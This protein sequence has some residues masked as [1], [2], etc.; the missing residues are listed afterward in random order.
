M[1]AG[2]WGGGVESVALFTGTPWK[3][4][5]HFS[6]DM[7]NK[8]ALGPNAPGTKSCSWASAW[9]I[10]STWGV[11]LLGITS[12]SFIAFWSTGGS[13]LFHRLFGMGTMPAFP[14]PFAAS[15]TGTSP[16]LSVPACSM[17]EGDSA[18]VKDDQ[19]ACCKAA[20]VVTNW[21]SKYLPT[22]CTLPTATSQYNASTPPTATHR[23]LLGM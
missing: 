11:G 7:T 4:R 20:T 6:W 17:G 10:A 8:S 14:T 9:T 2:A 23:S 1:L 16:A 15:S 21:V 3:M 5:E 19:S 12:T 13:C 22:A 18:L